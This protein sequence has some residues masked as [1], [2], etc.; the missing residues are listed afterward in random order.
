VTEEGRKGRKTKG[1]PSA[2]PDGEQWWS[3]SRDIDSWLDSDTDR[4]FDV[5][6]EFSMPQAGA[7]DVASRNRLDRI[8]ESHALL[9]QFTF[10]E[11]KI[12]LNLKRNTSP[13]AWTLRED[14]VV[15]TLGRSNRE[16]AGM[17]QDRNKEA[18]KKR[19][20]LLKSK[21]LAKRQPEPASNQAPASQS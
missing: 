4:H 18:V 16:I 14:L 9:K 7:E 17:L 10:K 12:L 15:L 19:L 1:S 13:K 3:D 8:K 6:E 20:Q 21:G 2:P 11:L 5:D